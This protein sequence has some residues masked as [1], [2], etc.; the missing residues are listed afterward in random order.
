MHSRRSILN[1]R[2][3]GRGGW[4]RVGGRIPGEK[5]YDENKSITADSFVNRGYDRGRE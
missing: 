3:T 4:K 5:Y 2:G 1:R